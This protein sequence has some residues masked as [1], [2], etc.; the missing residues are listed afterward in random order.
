MNVRIC[1]FI[2]R[3]KCSFIENKLE[4]KTI[5]LKSVFSYL[6]DAELIPSMKIFQIVNLHPE[7]V[8]TSDKEENLSVK[9]ILCMPILNG[10][11]SLIGVA[12]LINK[13]N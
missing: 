5:I 9:C 13:V 11:K 1:K 3:P 8:W 7:R 6:A 4:E 10:Q 12:Q 2:H